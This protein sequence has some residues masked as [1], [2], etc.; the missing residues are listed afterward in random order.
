MGKQKKHGQFKSGSKLKPGFK[1][2]QNK[3]VV[4]FDDKDRHEFLTG[5]HKR[6]VERRKAAV[7][8]I[9]NK[10]REEQKRVREERH[11][12]YLKMLKERKEALEEAD[13][14]DDVITSTTESVQYDHPNHTVTVT[15]ISD[16]DLSGT[17]LLE[18]LTNNHQAAGASDDEDEERGD[19]EEKVA[20]PRKAGNPLLSKK[21]QS[22]SASLHSFTKQKKK[23]KSKMDFRGRSQQGDRK[24]SVAVGNKHRLG[25]TTK[26]QRR[27]R[28]GRKDRSQD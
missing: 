1:K 19:E 13:E 28:T 24:S 20:L 27:K 17:R 26:K 7:E 21:I 15:T 2:R 25:K 9:K 16:L 10:L 22:L 18:S 11:K 23:R 3:C 8:E 4:M 6:K 5:F 14:L 12:E